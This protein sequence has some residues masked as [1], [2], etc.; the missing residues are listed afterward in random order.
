MQ[1]TTRQ[2]LQSPRDTP[3]IS[4]SDGESF[5]PMSLKTP[6][7]KRENSK[8]LSHSGSGYNGRNVGS[9]SPKYSVFVLDKQGKPLTPTTNAKARKMLEGGVAEPI[10]NK[11]SQMGIR[12]L[13]D[14]RKE[15]PKTALGV[16]FGTKFEGY[17]IAVGKENNLSVM[18]K[19]PDKKK[20]VNKLE[21]RRQLRR[22]RRWRTCR[23]RECRFDNR[24]RKDFLA[25]SQKV[26]VQSRMNVIAEFFKCYPIDAVALED[27]KFNHRDNR[28]GKN[29]STIEIGKTQINRW[30][31]QR[32]GLEMFTGYDTEACRNL[33]NYKKSSDKGAEVFNAHCSDALAIAT[34]LYAQEHISQ[35]K[36][37]IADNT[38]RPVRRRLHDTQPAKGGIR[39]KYS[40]GNFKSIRKGTICNY[41]QICGGTGNSYFIRNQNNKRIGRTNISWLSHKFKIHEVTGQFLSTINCGVSLPNAL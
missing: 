5:N 22:A 1:K 11:F 30:I 31:R 23:R 2:G 38:Y 40:T 13:V 17:A 19:L 33:Y 3:L 41:G 15:T 34:D 35:G 18:W 39:A 9:M 4:G 36:F 14:T 16:D 20:I 6:L 27:V 10:W 32:A 29:F 26:M 21:E 7:T 24:A 12:M 28:W 8:P 37:I 25:P